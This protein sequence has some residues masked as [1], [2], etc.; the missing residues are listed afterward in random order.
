M[1]EPRF[2]VV[3]V[4]LLALYAWAI[5]MGRRRKGGLQSLLLAGATAATLIPT[6]L[7]EI[8]YYLIPYLLLRIGVAEEEK[9]KWVFLALEL[10]VYALVN[11]LTII[12]FLT[13]TFEWPPNAVDVTRGEGTKMRFI[14]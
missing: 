14:W 7:I 12:L 2:A 5:A 10:G 1:V 13:R 9:G 8:R 6:P 3:P 4:Y 11:A